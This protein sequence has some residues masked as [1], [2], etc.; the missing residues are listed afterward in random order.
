MTKAGHHLQQKT[1]FNTLNSKIYMVLFQ[2]QLSRNGEALN[3]GQC[4]TPQIAKMADC[5]RENEMVHLIQDKMLCHIA[6]NNYR[7]WWP[8]YQG[9]QR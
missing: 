6:S 3:R 5:S 1:I 9:H 8:S 7:K 4:S 2:A